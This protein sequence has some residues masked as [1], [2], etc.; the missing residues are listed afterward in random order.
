GHVGDSRAYLLRGDDLHRLTHDHTLAQAL[1][2]IGVIS[3]D[4]VV[5]HR[6][7][8]VL[9][10]HL[11]GPKPVKADVQQARLADGDQVLLCTDGLTLM[12]DDA[13]I[14][15]IL[16]EANS[17]QEACQALIDAA[18]KEG[19]RDNVTVALARYR[20]QR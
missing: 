8:H 6:F 12:L 14:A 2:D 18:L 17:A 10:R 5:T 13:A 15:R 16:R 3:A 19:G 4:E 11:G 7:R 20:F 9:T 1:A